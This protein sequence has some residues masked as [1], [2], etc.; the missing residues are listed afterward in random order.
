MYII[1]A[2]ATNKNPL[3]THV[4]L[5][6]MQRVYPSGSRLASQLSTTLGSLQHLTSKSTS[7][8]K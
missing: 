6:M 8:Q 4:S 5:Y 3:Y 2:N 7:N 1:Y